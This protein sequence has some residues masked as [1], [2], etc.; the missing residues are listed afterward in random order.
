MFQCRVETCNKCRSG[1]P[2]LLPRA[3]PAVSSRAECTIPFL[4]T[5]L[6]LRTRPGGRRLEWIAHA[7][8]AKLADAADLKPDACYL[9][10]LG[11]QIR[12]L[13]YRQTHRIFTA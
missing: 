9:V 1:M 2:L 5:R 12:Y 8:M 10:S 11:K 3:L 6:G 4:R 13:V 7:G